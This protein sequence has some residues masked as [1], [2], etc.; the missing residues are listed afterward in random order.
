MS[1]KTMED[2]WKE[3]WVNGM[4][5]V[6]T[7]QQI[8]EL[9]EYAGF[10]VQCSFDDNLLDET[11]VKHCPAKAINETVDDITYSKF[12]NHIA[13]Y[14]EYPEEGCLGLGAEIQRPRSSPD[15]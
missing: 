2:V 3:Q 6:L 9:A 8:F 5:I 10:K 14:T 11:T 15:D 1:D 7:G 4:E 13:Y 12:Y